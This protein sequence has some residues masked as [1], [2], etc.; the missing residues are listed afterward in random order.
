VELKLDYGCDS[1][2]IVVSDDGC[3]TASDREGH[4]GLACMRERAQAIGATCSLS[5]QPGSGTVIR[6][7]ID[8]ALAY[9][10]AG[11]ATL[12]ARMRRRLPFSKAA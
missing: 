2:T 5:S 8:A 4:Y 11:N 7:D 1:L 10:G 6:V 3:G 9:A 12:L